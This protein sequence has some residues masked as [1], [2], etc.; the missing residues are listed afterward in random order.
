MAR[1]GRELL[2]SAE[3]Q[4][5]SLLGVFHLTCPPA[6]SP[7]RGRGV[8]RCACRSPTVCLCV[9]AP[10]G[11]DGRGAAGR[12]RD[13]CCVPIHKWFVYF[14]QREEKNRG[15]YCLPLLLNLA[16]MG[17]CETVGWCDATLGG[18]CLCV[19]V[20]VCGGEEGFWREL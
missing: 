3:P 20:H 2:K 11:L 18:V 12:C 4:A 7:V 16:V 14:L 6:S 1:A 15:K 8:C 10:P 19:C 9:L 17:L 5:C 13:L